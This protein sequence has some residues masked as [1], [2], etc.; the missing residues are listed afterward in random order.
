MLEGTIHQL[1]LINI[2]GEVDGLQVGLVNYADTLRG[3]QIG[4]FNIASHGGLPF[5]LGA[6]VGWQFR[7]LQRYGSSRH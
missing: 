2:G 5:M 3:V 7:S 6:N 1:G 4:A